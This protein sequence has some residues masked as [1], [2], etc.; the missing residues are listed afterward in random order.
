MKNSTVKI[1]MIVVAMS[2]LG[3][4]LYFAVPSKKALSPY[5]TYAS[6]LPHTYRIGFTNLDQE[7]SIKALPC[8]GT[9]PSWL[10]G[11]LLRNGP[12]QFS[13]KDSWVSNWFDGLAMVHA[14]SFDQGTVSYANAFLKT[15]TYQDVQRTGSMK[16]KGFVQD[17]CGSTFKK[18]MS[19]FIP[20]DRTTPSLPN[21]NVNIAEYAGRF[22]ALTETPLPIEFDP[23]TVATMGG[24][25]YDDQLPHR[26]IHDTAHPHYDPVRKEHV[27]YY[28][29]FG[30]TC[31]VNLFSIKDGTT[32]RNIVASLEVQEP[33]YMHSF[34]LTEHYAILSMIPLVANP[35][36]FILKDQA[37][38]KNFSWKP[39]RGTTL[40]VIDRINNKV[41][42]SYPTIPFFTFH[43]VNAF[44][45]SNQIIMDI[46]TYPDASVIFES[47]LSTILADQKDQ[48]S[49]IDETKLVR[50]TID[51]A[52]EHVTHTV[53]SNELLELPRINYEQVNG[54]EYQYLYAF[55]QNREHPIRYV[56]DFL[57]K[58]D[59][60]NNEVKRWTEPLCYPGE[61]VFIAAPHA[62]HEDEGV[63]VSVVLDAT[64]QRSFLLVLDAATFTELGRAEIPHHIP[65]GV[66]GIYAASR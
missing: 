13:T 32:T 29:T 22:V 64:A 43:H 24:L 15:P 54:K 40:V 35:L 26:N 50:F 3:S 56:S 66:H 23:A 11:T 41:V 62:Q 25:S 60:R 10:S 9:I 52:T 30:R 34:A 17:P 49:L 46:I 28:T 7:V 42:G 51:P 4:V 31:S 47:K 33:S 38:I 18:I 45:K 6:L 55:A 20:K 19:L 14:F 16:Y 12:A 44:E 2:V 27:G 48:T 65:Y 39:E 21:A 1:M 36:D 53:L 58:I 8:K 61:P 59:I 57:L 37:F 63:V 5:K